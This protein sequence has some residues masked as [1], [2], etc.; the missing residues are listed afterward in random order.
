M[1]SVPAFLSAGV[2]WRGRISRA[3]VPSL[4]MRGLQTRPGPWW[5]AMARDGERGRHGDSNSAAQM[6]EVLAEGPKSHRSVQPITL[7]L[8]LQGAR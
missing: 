2:S 6:G 7:D 3:A 8:R 1:T 5:P 4:L